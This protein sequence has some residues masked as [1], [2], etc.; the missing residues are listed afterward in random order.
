MRIVFW[1]NCLSPHQLPYILELGNVCGVDEVVVVAETDILQSRSDLGWNIDEND[2]SV[3]TIISPDESTIDCLLN[4]VPE[5]TWHL[6]SGI[7]GFKMVFDA[8]KKSLEYNTHRGLITESPMTY[9]YGVNWGKPLWMHKIRYIIQDKKYFPFIE[10]I[11]GIG[12]DAC[13]FF[14]SLNS[15]W[16]VVPFS[17]CTNQLPFIDNITDSELKVCFVGAL[18]K[19]KSVKTLLRIVAYFSKE[20]MSVSICGTGP[21][22][23]KLEHFV[24]K[25]RMNNVSFL[26]AVK[27]T[28]LPSVL[29]KQDILVLPSIHDGWGAVVNEAFQQGLYVICSGACGAKALLKDKKRGSV[30]RTGSSRDLRLHLQYCLTH[31]DEVRQSRIE[32]YDWASHHIDGKSIARYMADVLKGYDVIAPWL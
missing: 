4:F 25:K 3:K 30:F 1:Q 28:I 21:E 9:A 24:Q 19:R 13:S 27:N 26:G 22:R 29:A 2:T 10:V 5:D 16:K 7:R 14:R 6:F 11:F 8:F 20:S 23:R 17:Y 31:L 18:S 15:T 12:E 32:R